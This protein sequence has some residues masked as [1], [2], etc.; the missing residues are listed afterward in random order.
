MID[1]IEF[2]DQENDVLA[3]S[4]LEIDGT[5]PSLPAV[6]DRIR[7]HTNTGAVYEVIGREFWF[8]PAK[9]KM[10]VHLFLK[11]GIHKTAHFGYK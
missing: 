6:G 7:D 11:S 10:M 9:E 2:Y 1:R 8:D 3:F 4:P 5:C